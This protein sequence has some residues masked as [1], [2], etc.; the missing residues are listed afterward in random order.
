[1]QVRTIA[2]FL[3]L[4]LAPAIV[5]AAPSSPP[6]AI[7]KLASAVIVAANTG[8]AS[9]LAGLF[10]QDAAVV[11]ENPPFVWR[12][13]G[14]GVAWWHVVATVTR[15]AKLTHLQAI[16]VRTGEFKESATDAYMVQ[17]M[18]VTGVAAGKPF[19]EPGTMTYTFHNA[20]G[21]WLISTM[22]WTT[23]P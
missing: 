9:G 13:A 16:D 21:T 8:D 4:A 22:V 7:V 19:S 2:V 10:T 3:T 15:K 18:T 20:A 12:G 23:K 17:A 5:V 11:D 6:P 14:A 1:M